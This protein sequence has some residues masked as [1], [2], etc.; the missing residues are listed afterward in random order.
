MPARVLAEARGWRRA[1]ERR[2]D[3][4]APPLG[5]LVVGHLVCVLSLE[6]ALEPWPRML[7][8]SVSSVLTP[9][10]LTLAEAEFAVSL[11]FSPGERPLLWGEGG[12]PLQAFHFYLDADFLDPEAC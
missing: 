8:F 1:V 4:G 6:E 12:A 9:G 10:A 3:W 2:R 11:F 7:H 5:W